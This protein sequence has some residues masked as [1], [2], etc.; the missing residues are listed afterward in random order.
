LEEAVLLQ[1]VSKIE[2]EYS[3]LRQEIEDFVV[4]ARADNDKV[5]RRIEDLKNNKQ[6][7]ISKFDRSENRKSET[8]IHSTSRILKSI[9]SRAYN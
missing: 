9:G 6:A 2:N 1:E 8:S 4:A 5:A 3:L 7:T